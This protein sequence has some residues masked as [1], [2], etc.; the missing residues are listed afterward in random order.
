MTDLDEMADTFNDD[1]CF[2]ASGSCQYKAGPFTDNGA[3]LGWIAARRPLLIGRRIMG[4]KRGK[5]GGTQDRLAFSFSMPVRM[6][7]RDSSLPSTSMIS[8]APAG[9]VCMPETAVRIGQNT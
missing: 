4:G 1:E 6:R 9:V 5:T 3:V 7:V 2:A 8:V